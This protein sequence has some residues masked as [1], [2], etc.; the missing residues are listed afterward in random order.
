MTCFLKGNNGIL[1]VRDSSGAP[2]QLFE[3][4]LN[5]FG[6]EQKAVDLV[7]ITLTDDFQ[8][9][10][11]DNPTLRQAVDYIAAQNKNTQSLTPQQSQDLRNSLISL[12]AVT[13]LEGMQLKLQQAFYKGNIFNPTEASLANSGLYTP[14]ERTSILNDTELQL[15]IKSAVEAL[16]NSDL[17]NIEIPQFDS[18]EKM[19]VVNSFGKLTV[20]N[21]YV[22]QADVIN[23]LAAPESIEQFEDALAQLDYQNIQREG[24]YEEMQQY[25]RAQELDINLQPRLEVDIY[26][27]ITLGMKVE[28]NPVLRDSINTLLATPKEVIDANTEAVK[29]LL[30]T[31]ENN[32]VNQ[33]L[34]VVGLSEAEVNKPFLTAIQ[35]FLLNPSIENTQTLTAAYNEQFDITAT[36]KTLAI[37][38]KYI[39]PRNYVYSKTEKA[40]DLSLVE[41]N[42]LKVE[43]GTYIR[44]RRQPLDSLYEVV[45]SYPEK[46]TG[47]LEQYVGERISELN[48]DNAENAEELILMKMYFDAPLSIP[49]TVDT[50]AEQINNELFEGNQEYLTGDFIAD[51][52]ITA[53]K[54]KQKN[55]PQ[56]NNFYSNFEINSEGINLKNDDPLTV[57]NL[58]E[59]MGSINQKIANNLQQYS[60]ISKQLPNLIQSQE[61]T[62]TSK[63]STRALAINYPQTVAKL[64][65]E[66]NRITDE[67]IIVKNATEDFV[68]VGEDVYEAIETKG[69][70]TLFNILPKNNSEYKAYKAT[71]PKTDV[72]LQNYTYLQPIIESAYN[73][74]NKLKSTERE[75]I[76]QES[77]NCQ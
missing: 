34:D 28:T 61:E 68:R 27:A 36:P 23:K 30:T 14:Y 40:E 4:A 2:S 15:R 52:N 48:L 42:L 37:K 63:D 8:E 51:F 53:I 71:Q 24:L 77:F 7:A 19:E 43:E 25:V 47:E 49:Q 50:A 10:V 65:S 60:L 46:Y 17:E 39:A 75:K 38:P 21:P 44:V 20:L 58:N 1:S 5:E 73:Q 70:L 35:A 32:L 22:V 26:S 45:R 6:D 57:L 59:W 54:E 3:E 76:R 12:S 62:L 9:I 55:S 16:N 18:V 64:S 11:G 33:G 67:V 72:N 74:K 69:E 29:T 13:D 41:N 31:V 66:S 56:W